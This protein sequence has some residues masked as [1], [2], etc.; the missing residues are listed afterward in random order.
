MFDLNPNLV[1]ESLTR[2]MKAQF[3]YSEQDEDLNEAI[4]HGQS[5][6]ENEQ[7]GFFHFWPSF[8]KV[9]VHKPNQG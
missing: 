5:K 9:K 7:K 2:K 8:T 3:E 4:Q 6:I 1:K